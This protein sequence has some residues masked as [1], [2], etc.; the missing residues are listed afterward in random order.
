[1][2]STLI[3]QELKGVT[4]LYEK[5]LVSIMR[6]MTLLRDQNRLAGEHGPLTAEIARA[7][8]RISETKLQI[9]Q[10]DQDFRTDVFK[11]LREPK[12]KSPNSPS[13]WLP[14]R[15]NCVTSIFA[16]LRPASCTR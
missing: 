7:R 12:P 8:G 5:N 4:E 10:L 3:T 2:R 1:M 16:H 15:I 9:I 14:L 11:D 6:Y 13:A